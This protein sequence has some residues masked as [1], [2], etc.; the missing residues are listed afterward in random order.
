MDNYNQPF[1]QE[2]SSEQEMNVTQND[3]INLSETAQWAKFLGILGLIFLIFFVFAGLG[4]MLVGS[5]AFESSSELGDL[6]ISGAMIGF[7][8]IVI[9]AIY[10]YPTWALVKFG[11][12][13][14]TALKTN[15]QQKFSEGMMYL[16]RFFKFIGIVTIIIIAIYVLIFVALGVGMGI[17]S[18]GK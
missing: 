13:L 9:A 11:S 8:Y 18:L 4:I 15:N 7:A 12:L 6:G 1:G 17:G 2:F 10:F 14:R 16:K 3:K 5:A